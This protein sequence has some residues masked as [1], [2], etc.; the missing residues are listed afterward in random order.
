LWSWVFEFGKTAA[1]AKIV[2]IL[3]DLAKCVTYF[4]MRFIVIGPVLFAAVYGYSAVR[5]LESDVGGS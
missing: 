5:A 2:I 4:E 3:I 1:G